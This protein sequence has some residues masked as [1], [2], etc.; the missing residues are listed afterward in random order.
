MTERIWIDEDISLQG[1]VDNHEHAT[2]ATPVDHGDIVIT[3]YAPPSPEIF[4]CAVYGSVEAG[5]LP[6]G[7]PDSE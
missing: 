6:E 7:W 4:E 5:I 1:D 2:T 3:V